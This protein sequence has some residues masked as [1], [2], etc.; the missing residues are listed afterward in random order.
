MLGELREREREMD[1]E[2]R[3]EQ[4]RGR[5]NETCWRVHAGYDCP[6]TTTK[7]LKNNNNNNLF[8]Y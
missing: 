7:M 5:M 6:R 2:L 1:K 4:K 3:R 8:T